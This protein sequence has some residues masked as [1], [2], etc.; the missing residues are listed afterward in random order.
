MAI[1]STSAPEPL[2]HVDRSIPKPSAEIDRVV[3][4]RPTMP[5][6]SAKY[7]AVACVEGPLGFLKRPNNRLPSPPSNGMRRSFVPWIRMTDA[8]PCATGLHW[9]FSGADRF[10]ATRANARR[11]LKCEANRHV[12][13]LGETDAEHP[14]AVGSDL[15]DELVSQ[16]RQESHIINVGLWSVPVDLA[17]VPMTVLAV[18]IDHG[19]SSFIRQSLEGIARLNAHGGPV[20]TRSM[21]G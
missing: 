2:L 8:P 15:A 7:W 9:K 12:A 5:S 19:E 6:R 20:L 10:A 1:S 14:I 4:G 11:S 3:T 17:G 18:G 13:P 21:H 16:S